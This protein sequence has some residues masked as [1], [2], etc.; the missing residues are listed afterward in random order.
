MRFLSDKAML[1]YASEEYNHIYEFLLRRE[2]NVKKL[3]VKNVYLLA[4]AVG[5]KNSLRIPFS[6][7]GKTQ[8]RSEY[9]SPEDEAFIMNIALISPE[10]NNDIEKLADSENKGTVKKIIEEFANGGIKLIHENVLNDHWNG[11]EYN[12]SYEEYWLDICK[13]AYEEM[14]KSPF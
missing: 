3:E 9:L 11:H 13:Y 7:N 10:F 5:V 1:F 12:N 4:V 6:A 14:I 8:F 2:D